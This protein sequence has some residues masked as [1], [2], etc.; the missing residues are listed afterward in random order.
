[1]TLLHLSR[2]GI[3]NLLH[4]HVLLTTSKLRSINGNEKTLHTALLGV[5][6]IF[7]GDLAITVDIELYK[8]ILAIGGVVDDVVEGAG[9]KSGNL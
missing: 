8:E 2:G 7:L 5:L 6:D 9:G 1:V 3:V 4:A